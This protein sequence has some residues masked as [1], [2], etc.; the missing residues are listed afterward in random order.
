MR[1]CGY[2][3]VLATIWKEAAGSEREY[4]GVLQNLKTQNIITNI[5][6]GEGS[7]LGRN[8]VNKRTNREKRKAF[9]ELQ[10]TGALQKSIL[11][12]QTVP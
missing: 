3:A 9:H 12:K 8:W 5:L 11:R 1:E 2:T 4:R 7:T 10:V 6:K